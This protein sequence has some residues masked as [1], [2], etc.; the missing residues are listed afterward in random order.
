MLADSI[1]TCPIVPRATS[2]V[3]PGAAAARGIIEKGTVN[4][5]TAALAAQRRYGRFIS[6]IIPKQPAIAKNPRRSRW[7]VCSLSLREE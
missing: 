2:G 1:R 6:H 5:K 4:A 3:P 7:A